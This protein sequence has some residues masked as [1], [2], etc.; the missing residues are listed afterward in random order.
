MGPLPPAA[1]AAGIEAVVADVP[2]K[3]VT[4]TLTL[5]L[6]A[7]VCDHVTASPLLPGFTLDRV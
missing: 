4:E 7:Q 5:Q 2:T 3:V 1:V 6:R